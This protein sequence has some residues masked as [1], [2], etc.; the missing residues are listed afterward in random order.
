MHLETDK[1]EQTT[2]KSRTVKALTNKIKAAGL[3]WLQKKKSGDTV[4]SA[5]GS[6]SISKKSR[7]R[8]KGRDN[9]ATNGQNIYSI[10]IV[11]VNVSINVFMGK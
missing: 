10:V 1:I 6:T 11:D 7:R 5:P 2:G 8:S 3:N 4:G 9:I